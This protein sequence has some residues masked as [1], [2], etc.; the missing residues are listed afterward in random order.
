MWHKGSRERFSRGLRRTSGGVR[1]ADRTPDRWPCPPDRPPHTLRLSW[2][3]LPPATPW[4]TACSSWPCSSCSSGS[5]SSTA[6]RCS[7]R[8][9]TGTRSR[10]FSA[11]H[12]QIQ[13]MEGGENV[14]DQNYPN[15]PI[16]PIILWPLS[17]LSPSARCAGALHLVLPEGRHGPVCALLGVPPGGEPDAPFPAWAKAL[18]VMLSLTPDHRRPE[19]RQRQ[20]VHPVPRDGALYAFARG[21]DFRAGCSWR[22]AIACKVTPALFVVY[23]ALE[24]GWRVLLGYGG[25]AR[26]VLPPGPA[27]SSPFRTAH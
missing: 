25:W 9:R 22:L 7:P 2:P 15:P 27:P 12:P 1:H 24:A 19:A 18:A 10:P 21:K 5:V 4:P 11:G 23:F 3:R 8:A 13:A 17:E 6:G 20:P 26:P 16:M 14:Y